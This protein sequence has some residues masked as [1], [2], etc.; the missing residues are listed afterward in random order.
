MY[1][2]IINIKMIY[3]LNH[4]YPTPTAHSGQGSPGDCILITNKLWMLALNAMSLISNMAK[5]PKWQK[6]RKE[7]VATPTFQVDGPWT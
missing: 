2:N 4:Q 7:V 5:V 6:S 1:I 3:W